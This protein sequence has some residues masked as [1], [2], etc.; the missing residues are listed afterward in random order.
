MYDIL[1]LWYFVSGILKLWNFVFWYFVLTPNQP[2]LANFRQRIL[3]IA[4]DQFSL[5]DLL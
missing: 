3:V 4:K 5:K 2:C 1:S